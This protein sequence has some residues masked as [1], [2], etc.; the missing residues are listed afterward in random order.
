MGGLQVEPLTGPGAPAGVRAAGQVN[1]LTRTTWEDALAGL[2]GGAPR[3]HLHLAGLT[4][5]DAA[6][7]GAVAA[8][9]QR[10]EPGG[11]LFL[12]DPPPSL[13]RILQV[14]W[15]GI[16]GIEVQRTGGLEVQA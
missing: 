3:V 11:R 5:V 15:P 10:L 9:A 2:P 14:L 16:S 1:L 7:A 13:G 12:H 8:V 4:A 6:G